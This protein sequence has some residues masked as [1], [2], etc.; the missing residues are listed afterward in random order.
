MLYSQV[1]LVETLFVGLCLDDS[2]NGF[3]ARPLSQTT[4]KPLLWHAR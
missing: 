4:A 3:H 1:I 2:V